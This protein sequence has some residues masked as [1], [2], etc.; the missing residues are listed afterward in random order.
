MLINNISFRRAG[1]KLFVYVKY[2]LILKF[3]GTPLVAFLYLQFAFVFFSAKAALLIMTT[4]F[5]KDF[6]AK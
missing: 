4:G 1:L 3:L 5:F 6:S 2:P